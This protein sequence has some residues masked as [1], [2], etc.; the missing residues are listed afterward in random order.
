MKILYKLIL[1]L[2]IIVWVSFVSVYMHI[3]ID[4]WFTKDYYKYS[5]ELAS[6]DNNEQ[7]TLLASELYSDFSSSDLTLLYK[8]N[9]SNNEVMNTTILTNNEQELGSNIVANES[10]IVGQFKDLQTI[11]G[12]DLAIYSDVELKQDSSK[13]IYK[14][15]PKDKVSVC[16]NDYTGIWGALLFFALICLITIS[17][18]LY[19]QYN[20]EQL[21]ALY[22]DGNSI[23]YAYKTI[24]LNEL[25]SVLVV[26]AIV[27][28][29]V[30]IVLNSVYMVIWLHFIAL[31]LI[32]LAI[33]Y[34]AISYLFYSSNP[35]ISISKLTLYSFEIIHLIILIV[36]INFIGST[37]ELYKHVE[38]N[39][40]FAKI[41]SK[42]EGYDTFKQSTTGGE[43]L[44]YDVAAHKYVDYYNFLNQNFDVV[45]AKLNNMTDIFNQKNAINNYILV[46]QNY[47]NMFDVYNEDDTLISATDL[48]D[49][50][51]YFYKARSVEFDQQYDNPGQLPNVETRYLKEG[52]TL[53]YIEG[54]ME[55][56]G[57]NTI[58]DVSLVVIPD[59][60]SLSVIND[61]QAYN[62]INSLMSSSSVLVKGG[63]DSEINQQ[64]L[65]NNELDTTFRKWSSVTE[66]Y[67]D[68][69]DYVNRRLNIY[70]KLIIIIAIITVFIAI[71][72][73]YFYFYT[74][75]KKASILLLDGNGYLYIIKPYIYN[76]LLK[77][78][79]IGYYGYL[80]LHLSSSTIAASVVLIFVLSVII[81][82]TINRFITLRIHQFIKGER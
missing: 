24:I 25:Q 75:R 19:L 59:Y 9:S 72:D 68:L 36:L 42:L 14:T 73:L 47:F 60:L 51:I 28:L 11:K 29:L 52:Q 12:D 58:N 57:A 64:Y 78:V 41:S 53:W 40:A 79:I 39:Q 21:R 65:K 35:K 49:D 33:S 45:V 15:L 44:E 38:P 76:L 74:Y 71:I 3:S 8:Y 5:V 67:Q 32:I 54:A 10:I 18:L 4:T 70:L 81:I 69:I 1:I 17:S 30:M 26:T 22:I 7:N 63:K 77:L 37:I 2:T 16:S 66:N 13:Y 34:F 61:S 46:N 27:S 23:F 20:K 62:W 6:G 82:F 55:T 50:T 48:D 56:N 80:V 31:C 43:T